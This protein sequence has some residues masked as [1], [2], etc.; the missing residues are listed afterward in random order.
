MKR[1][2]FYEN[3]Y[4]EIVRLGIL[5][6]RFAKQELKSCV[7]LQRTEERRERE[8]ERRGGEE[9]GERQGTIHVTIRVSYTNTPFIRGQSWLLSWPIDNRAGHFYLFQRHFYRRR[10]RF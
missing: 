2:R 4:K 3:F 10:G 6:L 5:S 7:F 9:E 8:R 1:R